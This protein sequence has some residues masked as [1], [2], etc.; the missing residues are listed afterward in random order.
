MKFP[1]AGPTDFDS[2]LQEIRQRAQQYDLTGDWPTTD[3]QALQAA[4]AM[5]WAIPREFGG[6]ALSPLDL[7]LN[8][9]RIATAS[10]STALIL[11]Q[12]DS[13]VALVAAAEDASRQT[14]LLHELARHQ[15]FTTVG[16]AQLTTSRQG[17][18]PALRAE[19]VDGGYRLD[20]LIPWC[21]GA[22]M[23]QFI[24][25]GAT[26][27]DRQQIL[28]LLESKLPGVT[29]DP[30]MQLVALRSTFTTSVHL[31]NVLLEDR[32]LLRG[33]T[34]SALAGRRNS[35]TLGQTF[36]AM[37]LCRSALN[38]IA[39]HDSDRARAAH[40]R[41][42]EQLTDVRDEI[43][44]LCQ[45]GR[46]ADAAAASPRLRG[47]CNDLTLRATHAAVTLYK[48][49][50]LLADHP[51]QRLAREALFL[52]VWSCPNPVIDCTIDLLASV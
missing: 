39:D 23:A 1:Y 30:P 9:E 35:L 32:W 20:G 17:G 14:I 28:F 34:E 24:A 37:G 41:F 26:L 21:S 51:A 2:V 36:L 45:P 5:R 18:R 25:A 12:R 7:H 15:Q 31:N 8:Y 49:T 42:D 29:I 50:A 38:L 52:L 4:G 6:E 11:T 13:A 46:E 40:A 33:P 3:L 22:P 27:P 10:L 19:R 47:S 44:A 16:I 43:L 48:G